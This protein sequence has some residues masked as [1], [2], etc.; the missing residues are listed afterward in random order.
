MWKWSGGGV[1]CCWWCVFG[2]CRLDSLMVLV[3]GS[4]SYVNMVFGSPIIYAIFNYK[5]N[6]N[7]IYG[8][9]PYK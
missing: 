5:I 7:N 9:I 8:Q 4:L 6:V 2:G 1:E 3:F